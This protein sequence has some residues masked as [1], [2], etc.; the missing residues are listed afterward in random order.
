VLKH[1]LKTAIFGIVV[2]F[3]AISTGTEAYNCNKKLPTW[4]TQISTIQKEI[5]SQSDLRSRKAVLIATDP[6]YGCNKSESASYQEINSQCL[7]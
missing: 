4:E 2:L 3:F 1:P 7:G 6:I 5:K